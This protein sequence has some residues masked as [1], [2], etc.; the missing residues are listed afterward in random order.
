[1]NVIAVVGAETDVGRR[2]AEQLRRHRDGDTVVELPMSPGRLP[3]TCRTLVLMSYGDHDALARRRQSAVAGLSELL[4]QATRCQVDQVVLLSSAMVYGAW[5]NNP[6]PL[7]EDALLRPDHD[8]V[9]AR[10]LAAAELIVDT[11]RR[12]DPR[13]RVAVV[14]PVPAMAEDGTSSVV[15]ALAAGYGLRAGEDDAPCQFVHVDDVASAVSLAVE[16]QLDG[17]FN[18]APEGAIPAATVRLLS[19]SR[20]RLR[21]PGRAAD[22][23]AQLRWRFQR[24]P[25]PPGLR[26]YTR[27]SWLVASDRLR[28]SGWRATATNEQV[29]VEGTESRWWSMLTPQRKQEVSLALFGVVLVGAVIITIRTIRRILRGRT[30]ARSG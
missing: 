16:Q 1:M 15:R 2:V 11:W 23:A 17:V 6:V 8:F 26:P 29:Y 21:L 10:Q 14:R 9:F 25:I 7:T 3:D 20:P 24:G 12:E 5:P 30:A 18:V 4:E 28:H 19:G 13:R 27:W 22:V